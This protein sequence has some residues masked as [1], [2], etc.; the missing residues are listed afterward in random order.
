MNDDAVK[1]CISKIRDRAAEID[2]DLDPDIAN[3]P[4]VKL[5]V[6]G[7]WRRWL[8]ASPKHKHEHGC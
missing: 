3:A 5:V 6:V 8:L 7:T 4:R 1:R 2:G